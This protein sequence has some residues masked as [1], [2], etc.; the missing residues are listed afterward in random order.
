MINSNVSKNADENLHAE[1]VPLSF[2]DLKEVGSET[3]L[4]H[5]PICILFVAIFF[6]FSFLFS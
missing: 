5:T 2:K 1:H 3:K 6:S 4:H